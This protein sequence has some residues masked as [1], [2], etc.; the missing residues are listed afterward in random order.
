MEKEREQVLVEKEKT[1]QLYKTQSAAA[2][3][4]RELLEAKMAV[5]RREFESLTGAARKEFDEEMEKLKTQLEAVKAGADQV[6]TELAT[7]QKE[8]TTLEG[9][10]DKALREKETLKVI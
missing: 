8:V 7:S 6:T 9:E 3:E 5:Q 10:L 1:N 4:E 2:K